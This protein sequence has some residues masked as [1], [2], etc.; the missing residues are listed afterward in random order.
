[1]KPIYL[2]LLC[3]M[4]VAGASAQAAG[5]KKTGFDPQ[6]KVYRVEA[7]CGMCEFK[8]KG[9]DCALAIRWKG[10]DYYVDGTGIDDHG[11]AH[12]KDLVPLNAPHGGAEVAASEEVELLA[13]FPQPLRRRSR[14]AKRRRHRRF[15]VSRR[16]PPPR[17]APRSSRPGSFFTGTASMS[18]AG[19]FSTMVFCSG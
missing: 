17:P 9:K 16:W 14:S 5:G 3:L 19:S 10:K 1:M 4:G 6:K 2:I 18:P 11:D 7:A 13:E 12:D 15:L 8:M